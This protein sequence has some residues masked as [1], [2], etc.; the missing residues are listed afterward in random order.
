MRPRI[1]DIR[2]GSATAALKVY[3]AF[4]PVPVRPAVSVS[5]HG[6]QHPRD[7]HVHR[8][9]TVPDHLSSA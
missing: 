1:G 6:A 2:D 7:L 4:Y 9:F 5:D 3:V 8:L